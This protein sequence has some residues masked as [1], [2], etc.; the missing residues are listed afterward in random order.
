MSLIQPR[1]NLTSSIE[2]RMS[3]WRVST[4]SYSGH[5]GHSCWICSTAVFGST[6]HAKKAKSQYAGS[7]PFTVRASADVEVAGR[8]SETARLK[9]ELGVV[10]LRWWAE[11]GKSRHSP[12]ILFQ[13]H[14]CTTAPPSSLD[15][16]PS[17][18]TISPL[19]AFLQH[20]L[21]N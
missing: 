4:L 8:Q 6:T 11:L 3:A 17:P 2:M 19:K 7:R 1:S 14:H 15:C 9:G 5:E 12:R 16:D 18:L 13:L 21:F 20:K 10:P